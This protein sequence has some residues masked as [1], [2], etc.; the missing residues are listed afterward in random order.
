MV[1]SSGGMCPCNARHAARRLVCLQTTDAA[2]RD[3]EVGSGGKLDSAAKSWEGI[4]Y[5]IP[6]G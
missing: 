4:L 2:F 6:A 5:A 3:T 1:S